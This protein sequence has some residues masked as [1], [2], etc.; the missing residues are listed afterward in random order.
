VLLGGDKHEDW[1][2]WYE[3]NVP[4]ADDRYHDYLDELRSEGL[5]S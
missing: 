3:R 4:L 5:I 2:G 1:S